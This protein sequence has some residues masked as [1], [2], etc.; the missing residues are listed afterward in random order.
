MRAPGSRQPRTPSTPGAAFRS[1]LTAAR[2]A[3]REDISACHNLLRTA[4]DNREAEV[5]RWLR[6]AADWGHGD[7]RHLVGTPP[8]SGKMTAGATGQ[9]AGG[10]EVAGSG[11]PARVEDP[12]FY[13][14]LHTFL[15]ARGNGE[16]PEPGRE[17]Q[18]E[19]AG[20]DEADRPQE[21][22]EPGGVLV[23]PAK[24]LPD[25][26]AAPLVPAHRIRRALL[27]ALFSSF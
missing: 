25:R 15:H 3:S 14:E 18:A 23:N 4:P 9:G 26:S 12:E 21:A 7:A 13:D 17:P 16:G 10:G 20:S 11:R 1:A 5:L 24:A 8:K 2:S 22:G 19:A 6:A 27:T